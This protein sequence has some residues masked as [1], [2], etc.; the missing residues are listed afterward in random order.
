MPFDAYVALSCNRGRNNIRL[1]C[2]FD[3]RRFEG[4][5]NEHHFREDVIRLQTEFR[6]DHTTK[7]KWDA[8]QI[9]QGECV[10]RRRGAVRW[11]GSVDKEVVVFNVV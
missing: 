4:H 10:W 9:R 3:E 11:N 2:D 8:F 6:L 1:L 5:P 7:M